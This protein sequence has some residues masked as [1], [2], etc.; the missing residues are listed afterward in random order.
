VHEDQSADTRTQEKLVY[1]FKLGQRRLRLDMLLVLILLLGSFVRFNGLDWG[2]TNFSKT[3]DSEQSFFDFHPDESSNVRVA[4]NFTQSDSWRPTGDLYGQKLDYSLYGA[5]TVYLHVFAVRLADVFLDFTPYDFEDPLSK[6][7][8]YM[9][10]RWLTAIMGLACIVLLYLA[11]L[12]LYDRRTARLAAILLA[13]TAF[14]AQSGRFGTVDI[15]MVFFGLWSFYHSARLLKTENWLHLCLAALAAGLAIST[16][17][18]A[19]LIVFPLVAAE[20]IRTFENQSKT[21]ESPAAKYVSNWL[22]V[23][24]GKRLW[25]AALI[26]VGMFFLLNPYAILDWKNY[27]FA[28]HAFGLMHIIRN[29]RGEFFYPFQIQFQ[30][31]QP[32]WFLLSN[33]FWW[34]AGPAIELVGLAGALWMLF[35]RKP[36][37]IVTLAWFLPAFFMTSSAQVMFMR[38]SLP[39]LPLLALASSRLAIALYAMARSDLNRYLAA[40]FSSILVLLSM[41][42]TVALA[43]VHNAEDSRIM[44]GRYLQKQLPEGADLLHERS[45]NTIKLVIDMPRY[46]NVCLQI[47][48]VY[49]ADG[50]SGAE[51]LDYLASRID[52]VDWA[53]I[54]ESNRKLGYERTSR[55]PAENIF[56]RDLF[57][58]K[59]GFSRDTIFQTIPSVLGIPVND[60]AAEFSLRYYDHEE[61]HIF[62]KTDPAALQAGI[63]RLK[64]ELRLNPQTVD[65]EVNAI[66]KAI[67]SGDLSQAR[68]KAARLIE[69]GR[70]QAVAYDKLAIIFETLAT[71]EQLAGGAKTAQYFEQ[72]QRMYIEALRQPAVDR[73]GRMAGLATFL[74]KIG[75]IGSAL[76]VIQDAEKNGLSSA[77]LSRLKASLGGQ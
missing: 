10:I 64:R 4:R 33:V 76:S 74:V 32:F 39:F 43:S 50:S 71:K 70:G 13:F 58:E 66:N 68:D 53:A 34:A 22:K 37:D 51:K 54:L 16:K 6:K 30:E 12:H 28:D 57:A 77:A 61:I 65:F 36:G 38:Y 48:T 29:V 9:A 67:Q 62:R 60:E 1:Q 75:D 2:W 26:T 17:V 42:W 45:A 31:I 69:S 18:N 63:E 56:Y 72:A 14:F 55:Y 15:P 7:R 40:G 46:N 23:L 52:A 49:R 8:T 11:A 47:P 27:L 21:N 24:F 73:A 35:K 25:L 19:L 5:T 44:A 59:L 3:A 20:L 41:G